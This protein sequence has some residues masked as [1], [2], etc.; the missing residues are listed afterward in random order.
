LGAVE[1]NVQGRGELSEALAAGAENDRERVFARHDLKFLRVIE[2]LRF[3]FVEVV[4]C[5]EG[6]PHDVAEA[7][8]EW[9]KAIKAAVVE[10][11]MPPCFADPTYGHFA[12]DRRLSDTDIAK[13][14][15]SRDCWQS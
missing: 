10:R 2:R 8:G 12:N 15:R 9:A 5:V 1:G 11:K 14:T 6:A 4:F 13:N 3:P 7:G